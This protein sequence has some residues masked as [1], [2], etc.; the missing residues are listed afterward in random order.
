VIDAGRAPASHTRARA[1]ARAAR[2]R[3]SSCSS[4]DFNTLCDVVSDA[5]SP[6]PPR[7][8]ERERE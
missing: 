7:T 3:P 5:L 1:S 4:I 2:T 6:V 8:Y